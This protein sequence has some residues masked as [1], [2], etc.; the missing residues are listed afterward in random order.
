MS[1]E[2]IKSLERQITTLQSQLSAVQSESA[3]RDKEIKDLRRERRDLK[4]QMETIEADAKAKYDELM[5]Q[6]NQEVTTWETEKAA[7]AKERDDLQARLS[8]APQEKDAEIAQLKLGLRTRDFRDE[9][10][11]AVGDKA[12]DGSRLADGWSIDDLWHF[13]G[14]DP[15]AVETLD[16]A[17]INELI[18]K[19]KESKPGLFAV[20][21]DAPGT[22]AAPQQNGASQRAARPPLRVDEPPSRGARDGSAGQ[23]TYNKREIAVPGWEKRRPELYEAI[24]TET[25]VLLP[26]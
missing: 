23:V 7:I 24:S 4:A 22:G 14:F 19:V 26:D 21:R 15:R 10:A 25:A 1:D 5:E 3:G 9:F 20:S 17:Q 12:P 2:L 16:P 8:A 18:G 13:G 6:V 11:K